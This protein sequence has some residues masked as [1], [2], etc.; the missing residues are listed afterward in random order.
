[1]KTAILLALAFVCLT[2]LASALVCV[3]AIGY[4]AMTP[5]L[6]DGITTTCRVCLGATIAIA[7]ASTLCHLLKEKPE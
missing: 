2:L 6:A 3:I 1:M 4:G 7:L 5:S